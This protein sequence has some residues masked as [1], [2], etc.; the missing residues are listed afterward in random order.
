[1]KSLWEKKIN[2]ETLIF[3]IL[4][5]LYYKQ[6]YTIASE[7]NRRVEISISL[8]IKIQNYPG[9]NGGFFRGREEFSTGSIF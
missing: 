8:L 7:L 3:W 5:G 9:E 6:C 4:M 1:M 2:E